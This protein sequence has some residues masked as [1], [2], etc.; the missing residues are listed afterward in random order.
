MWSRS[1]LLE[2]EIG[3]ECPSGMG[4]NQ[5]M[6]TCKY[7]PRFRILFSSRIFPQNSKLF[8]NPNTPPSPQSCPSMRQ[9]F[10][11]SDRQE[12]MAHGGLIGRQFEI[13]KWT[14]AGAGKY[15]GAGLIFLHL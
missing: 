4:R 11:E 8:A 9:T 13:L 1:K 5:E 6:L 2:M 3:M 12:G 15:R 10:A 7:A 14:V